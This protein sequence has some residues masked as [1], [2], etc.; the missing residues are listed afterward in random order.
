PQQALD[1]ARLWK[2]ISPTSPAANQV[3]STLLVLNGRWDDARPLLQQQLA[4]VPATHR[5]EAILQ[6]QQQLSRT[7]DPAG[8]A[9][10]LQDLTKND[11]KL[12]ETQLAL[13]RAR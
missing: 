4:A 7:S 13:A 12:P 2:E 9:T 10:L 5:G 6:L 8:A 3:L 11:T 1:S